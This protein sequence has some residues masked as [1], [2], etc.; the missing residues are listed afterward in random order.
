M[1]F[2]IRTLH[3][4]PAFEQSLKDHIAGHLNKDAVFLAHTAMNVLRFKTPLGWFGR[5]K[6][7]KKGEYRGKVDIKKAGIFAVTEGIKVLALEAGILDGGTRERL[8]GLL[9]AKILAPGQAQDLE[10][11]FDFLVFLRLRCQV[12]AIREEREP[13]NHVSLDHLNRMEKG[14][15]KLALKEVRSFQ[16]FLQ[17]HFRLDLFSQ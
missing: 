4:D 14:R 2:D 3:G 6:T 10:A 17:R 1:F 15:L 11:S 9:E 13:N 7:E 16:N 12:R 5:I 8:Q